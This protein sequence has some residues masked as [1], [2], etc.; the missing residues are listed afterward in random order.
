L[1]AAGAERAVE[2]PAPPEE[3]NDQTVALVAQLAEGCGRPAE[4]TQFGFRVQVPVANDRLQSVH[5]GFGG[6]DDE[7]RDLVTLLS[8]CGKVDDRTAHVLM[9][10]NARMVEGQFAIRTLGGEEY[11]VV[12]ANRVAGRPGLEDIGDLISK[13]AREADLVESQ[14]TAGADVY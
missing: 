11:F 7:G 14:L 9:K 8:V 1:E 12:V 6:K 2:P 13:L 3:P 4:P 10:R 5:V